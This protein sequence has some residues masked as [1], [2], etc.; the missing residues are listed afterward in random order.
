MLFISLALLCSLLIIVYI[1]IRHISRVISYKNQTHITSK[2][3]VLITG[4]CLGIG[5]EILNALIANFNCKVINLDIRRDQFAVLASVYESTNLINIYC[6][7]SDNTND[8]DVLLAQSNIQLESIDILINNAGIAFNQSFEYLSSMKISKTIQINLLSPMLLCKA[9]IDSKKGLP[10]HIVT[11]S[12][13]MSHLV[14]PNSSD[15]IATKWGLFGFHES[16]RSEYLYKKNAYFTI[17]CPFAVNTGMFPGFITPF[18]FILN[19]INAKDYGLEVIKSIV[20]KDKIVYSPFYIEYICVVYLLL[21]CWFRDLIQE[22][23]C[24]SILV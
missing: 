16:L 6:D 5:R 24:K 10:I 1:V 13:A 2:T 4:G 3:T 11:I 19:V 9:V 18:P 15:Y 14:S 20:L 7:L 17:F 8:F 23:I 21:P 22:Y 12:S